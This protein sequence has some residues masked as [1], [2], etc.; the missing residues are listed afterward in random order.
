MRLKN[1][2]AARPAIENSDLCIKTPEDY[3]GRWKESFSE[4]KPI[5]LEIGMGKGQFIMSMAAIN[6]GNFYLGMELHASVLYRGL[7]KLEEDPLDNILLLNHPA[8]GLTD[9]FAAGEI[10]GIY[11]NFSDPWPKE[12]HAKRR[13]TSPAF[14]D[15]YAAILERDGRIEFKTDN[16][17]LFDYSVE[18]IGEHGDFDI[19]ELTYDLHA[20]PVLSQ[21]NIMTEYEEKFSSM[22][23]PICKLIAVRN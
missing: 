12:R 8:E 4:G 20:D 15:R 3:K 5:F 19:T 13:L 17:A 9:M 10:E 7:Q 18:A 1:I 14:L 2:P 22:G 6:P 23:N 11:L 21:G 16:R